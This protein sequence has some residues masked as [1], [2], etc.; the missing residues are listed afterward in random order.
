MKTIQA[1]FQ[2]LFPQKRARQGSAGF[3]LIELLVV[4]GIMGVLAAVG[5]PV[6]QNYQNRAKR[7][8]LDRTIGLIQ[9]SLSACL[10]LDSFANCAS[11]GIN[12]TLQASP[13]STIGYGMGTDKACYL[14]T[15]DDYTGC[16][17]FEN[18]NSGGRAAES[19]SYGFPVGTNC[20][21]IRPSGVTCNPHATLPLTMMGSPTGGACP[22]GCTKTINSTTVTCSTGATPTATINAGGCGTT[23]T[24]TTASM[25]LCGAG[26]GLCTITN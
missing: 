6:Y 9:T 22:S 11:D 19:P 25:A 10:A 7:G 3:S 26:S 5:I 20:N 4:I 1:V 14:V 12:G 16:V 15:I 2:A 17:R 23:G 8:S 18:N 21:N 13:G 24:S